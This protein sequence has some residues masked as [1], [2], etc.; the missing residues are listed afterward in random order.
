[1]VHLVDLEE[2]RLVLVV[3]DDGGILVVGASQCLYGHDG[4]LHDDVPFGAP[5]EPVAAFRPFVF[6][7]F[8]LPHGHH[9]L[10]QHFA[11]T[12]KEPNLI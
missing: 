10:S 8:G 1:M 11:F 5:V 2:C 3:A 9:V 7:E 4:H 6:P 12:G